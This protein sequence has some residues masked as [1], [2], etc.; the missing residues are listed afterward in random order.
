[1][2][3]AAGETKTG[4]DIV[5]TPLIA[6]SGTITDADGDPAPG[7]QVSLMRYTFSQGRMALVANSAGDTDDRGMFRFSNTQPGRYYLLASPRVSAAV[8][9]EIRGRSAQLGSL[10]TYYPN[11]P[12]LR[13][14]V[15]ITVG[16]T[17]VSNLNIRLRRGGTFSIAGSLVG[18]GGVPVTGASITVIP[19]D[20]ITPLQGIETQM[21]PQGTYQVSGL[22]AGEYALVARASGAPPAANNPSPAPGTVRPTAVSLSGRADV[23]IGSSDLQNVIIRMSPGAAITGRLT[24]D[25]GTDLAT[26]L[27]SIPGAPLN[28]LTADGTVTTVAQIGRTASVTLLSAEGPPAGVTGQ[29]GQ[30]GTF[31]IQNIP[32]LKRTLQTMALPPAAY[33]K[34]VRFNGQDVTRSLLDLSSGQG[35]ILEIQIGTKGAEIAAVP[36]NSIGETPKE[37]AAVAVWPRV[38]N[39]GISSGDVRSATATTSFKAQGLAPGEYFVAALDAPADATFTEFLK[40]PEFLARFNSAAVKVTIKEGESVAAE[41]R[42]ISRDAIQ[43]AMA[44]FP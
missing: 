44:Q 37:G 1:V 32:P 20:S 29:V 9:G 26:F 22:A 31:S 40:S 30:D 2:D 21:S 36:R 33:L 41:P 35:G 4:I 3:V 5:L 42:I 39:L 17:E 19:K 11:S 12:E 34:S 25:G 15:A 24:I 14:A 27:S 13:G 18:A 16:S 10:P 7:T 23:T 28:R 43:A 6:V 8:A 38:P